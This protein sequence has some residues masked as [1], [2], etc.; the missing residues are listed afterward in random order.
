MDAFNWIV[1]AITG[2][3]GILGAVCTVGLPIIVVVGL[4]LYLY[5]RSKQSH[6]ARESAQSWPGVSGT[7]LSSN[8]QMRRTGRS[9]SQFPVVVYQ[10]EV[11]GKM[12]Q[13]QTIRAGE[14]FLHVQVAGQAKATVARYPV[15]A[16]VTVYYNPANPAES[17]LE[18]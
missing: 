4:G 3:I 7:V 11:G 18:R 15:G 8:L 6:A 2:L 5:R 17:A 12:F 10:Y 13:N 16:S 14:Q 9:R 1:A